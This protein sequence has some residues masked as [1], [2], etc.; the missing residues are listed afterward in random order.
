MSWRTRRLCRLIVLA[1]A[2]LAAMALPALA[3]AN[4]AV[5]VVGQ[6][7]QLLASTSVAIG[8]GGR[9]AVGWRGE[10]MPI[11]CANDTAYQALELAVSGRWDRA[12][13]AVEILGER[14][15]FSPNEEFWI[16]YDRNVTSALWHFDEWGACEL[17][18]PSNSISRG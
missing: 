1:L 5:R 11:R 3:S 2:A 9:D 17:H 8:E 15:A 14:H 16:L 13:F 12:A 7:G 4:V 6:R 10:G 18:L